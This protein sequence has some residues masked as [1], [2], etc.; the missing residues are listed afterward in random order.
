M[1]IANLSRLR[2]WWIILRKEVTDNLRDRRTLT[3]LVVSIIITPLLMFGLIWFTE[4]TVKEETDLANAEPVE[5]PV[6]GAVNAPN[7]MSWL[8][9]NNIKVIDPPSDPKA[10]VEAGTYRAV[11][12]I[13][14]EYAARYR[15]GKTAPVTM[16]HD[17]SISGL[18]KIGFGTAVSAL[19]AYSQKIGSMRLLARGIESSTIQAIQVNTSDVARPEAKA[20]QLL[21]MLPYL[22]VMFIMAGGMYLAI[23]S[24]A[25]EREKGS[26]EPL[27][28]QPVERS[29]IL[30]AKLSATIVFSSLTL[31]LMLTG[32]A[33][34]F[35]YMP[36]ES[37]SVSVG[38]I[39]VAKIFIFC[40]PLVFLGSALMVLLASF[41]KSHKE[42]QS[43][44]SMV[45]L[46]PTLPLIMLGFLSPEP[47]TSTMWIPSLS[48]GLIILE[49]IKGDSIPISLIGLSAL[50]STLCASALTWLAVKLYSR[51]RILG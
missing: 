45:M 1:P 20:G 28:T 32:F 12:V 8:R 19:Q 25:G 6:V 50:V 44:L 29:T 21:N 49:T 10:A 35:K 30:L 38:V 17:S 42:A 22:I 33:I 11:L 5:L 24:T 41:T 43:Y 14:K 37:V 9:Q 27:I 47:S 40:L 46:V 23:D 7:L 2:L 48:H 4:K 16:L 13:P 18:E 31:L 51:E 36:I 15:E 34:A 39:K 26:L 3:T